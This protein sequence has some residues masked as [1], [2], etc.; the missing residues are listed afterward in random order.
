MLTRITSF[1]IAIL[2]IYKHSLRQLV[3]QIINAEEESNLFIYIYT[4]TS[5][6]ELTFAGTTSVGMLAGKR[7]FL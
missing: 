1:P 2:F 4:S 3:R 7:F 5:V 6:G